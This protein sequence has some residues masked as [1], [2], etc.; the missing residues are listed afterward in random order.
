MFV[1]ALDDVGEVGD[2]GLDV[3]GDDGDGCEV[4]GLG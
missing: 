4:V 3:L 1:V 2:E